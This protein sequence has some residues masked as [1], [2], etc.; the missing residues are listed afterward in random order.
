MNGA[1]LV[2]PRSSLAFGRAG[3]TLVEL[4]IALVLA[5]LLILGV[6]KLVQTTVEQQREVHEQ[7]ALNHQARK[8]EGILAQDLGRAGRGLPATP[9]VFGV[10]L[11]GKG[12]GEADTLTTFRA[13]GERMR[14]SSQECDQGDA[15]CVSV[16][17]DHEDRLE[18]GTLLFIGARGL[19]GR[20][21]ELG[22]VSQ[23][24]TRA[25]GA[26]GP[27]SLS[28]ED[29]DE[30]DLE[31]FQVTGSTHYPPDDDPEYHNTPCPQPFFADGTV[32]EEDVVEGVQGNVTGQSCSAASTTNAVYTDL[33][34]VDRTKEPFGLP[35][36]P[37][38]SARSGATAYPD[39]VV[40]PIHFA[41]YTIGTLANAEGTVLL[42]S[43]A[44]DEEGGVGEGEP[45]TRSTT[46]FRA[47]LRHASREEWEQGEVIEEG[48][49]EFESG[50]PNLTRR[51]PPSEAEEVIAHSFN[52]SYAS[53]AEIRVHFAIQSWT[54]GQ[55]GEP[56]TEERQL[57]VPLPRMTSGGTLTS[58]TQ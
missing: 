20:I 34:Y 13:D 24:Y 52:V 11:A 41:R 25:R 36:P 55:R 14:A 44:L 4:T 48:A 18:P 19:G 17:G 12:E 29:V 16:R 5:S 9:N 39:V 51:D 57:T 58:P 6:H 26:D 46:A 8:A 45:V 42:R 38:F 33:T 47:E 31:G 3:F 15:P 56:P 2:P 7:V 53:V 49:L 43:E 10:H 50:N 30:G 32:C 37:V 1:P 28:C 22:D 27:E 21:V 23:S 35:E 40:Q 54:A